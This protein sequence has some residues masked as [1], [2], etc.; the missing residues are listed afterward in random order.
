MSAVLW[1]PSKHF[2]VAALSNR[3]EINVE[4]FT[5]QIAEIWLNLP[6]DS[7]PGIPMDQPSNVA[8]TP[9][10][11]A[12]EKLAIY[13]G[14]YWSEELQV[15]CHVEVSGDKLALRYH[16]HDPIPLTPLVLL[17]Y[18]SACVGSCFLP[19]ISALRG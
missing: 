12:P 16:F 5:R 19:I 17:R 14:D 18:L 11:L 13:G 3:G 8:P 2:G 4:R 6:P 10:R 1:I 9:I 15:V 7:A